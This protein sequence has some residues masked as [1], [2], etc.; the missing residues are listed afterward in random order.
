[1]FLGLTSFNNLSNWG[2]SSVKKVLTPIS[3]EETTSS[4]VFFTYFD[5]PVEVFERLLGQKQEDKEKSHQIKDKTKIK[6]KLN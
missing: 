3:S 1:M 6:R 5:L 4:K 2:E